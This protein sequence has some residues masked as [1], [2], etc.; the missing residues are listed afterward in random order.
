MDHNYMFLQNNLKTN[1]LAEN[2]FWEFE[3]AGKSWKLSD[4]MERLYVYLILVENDLTSVSANLRA[5]DR[6]ISVTEIE[7]F[8]EYVKE[9]H[10]TEKCVFDIMSLPTYA[11]PGAPLYLPNPFSYEVPLTVSQEQELLDILKQKN[12]LRKLLLRQWFGR[13]IERYALMP[14]YKKDEKIQRSGLAISFCRQHGVNYE[15]LIPKLD[16]K[17]NKEETEKRLNREKTPFGEC[18]NNFLITFITGILFFGIGFY[19]LGITLF[20]FW[21]RGDVHNEFDAC[22]TLCIVLGVTWNALLAWIC[23]NE[24]SVDNFKTMVC[25]HLMFT[26]FYLIACI[27]ICSVLFSVVVMF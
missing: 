19:I 4:S 10:P 14:R 7:E 5:H 22:I 6:K 1:L 11:K 27:F 3:L 26:F 20:N 23:R 8:Y 21:D 24:S 9:T 16:P 25:S 13:Y 18:L 15:E 2:G 17:K 12:D